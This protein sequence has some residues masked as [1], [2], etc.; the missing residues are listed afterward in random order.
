VRQG[1]LEHDELDGD[2][3]HCP[4]IGRNG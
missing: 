2:R 3:L 1:L 4:L